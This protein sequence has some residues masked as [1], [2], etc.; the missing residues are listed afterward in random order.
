[1]RVLIG[2]NGTQIANDALGELERAGLPEDAE[3]NILCVS[4]D[5]P[6]NKSEAM[7]R[8]ENAADRLAERSRFRKINAERLSGLPDQEILNR[9]KSFVPD[10]IVLR[11]EDPTSD[12]DEIRQQGLSQKILTE[13]GCS[14]RIARNKLGRNDASPPRIV[15][16][17]DGSAGGRLAVEA[18]LTRT[19]PANTEVRLVVV[20]DRAVLG[21]IGRFSP[22]MTNPQVEAKIATQW[23]NTL[24]EAP[25]RKLKDAGL[26]AVLWVEPGC[27]KEVLI[28]VAES[29][30]AD[31]IFLGPHCRNNLAQQVA[32]GS[33]SAGVA[34]NAHCSVEVVRTSTVI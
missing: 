3:V 9:A 34:A 13:A 25:L 33:V 14:V 8:L 20:T 23:A 29:W 22:Q 6:D 21:S 2:Y 31:S 4:E 11:E 28:D 18:V 24:A 26:D 5:E 7:L 10:L 19:W 15:I 27:P 30:N 17:Y 16:G 12:E 1:M 32:L